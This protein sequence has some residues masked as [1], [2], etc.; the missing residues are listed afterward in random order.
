VVQGIA[1]VRAAR[2]V[3]VPAW[4]GTLRI[5]LASAATLALSIAFVALA[6]RP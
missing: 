5:Q 2:L 4:Y 3:L 6:I 1:D